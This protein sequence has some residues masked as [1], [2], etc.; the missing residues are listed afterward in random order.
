MRAERSRGLRLITLPERVEALLWA[1][2]RIDRR[3]ASREPLFHMYQPYARSIARRHRQARCQA[4]R[5]DAEQWAYEGLLQAIDSYDPMRGSPFSGFAR[6]RIVGAIRDGIARSTELDA[7][8]SVR[9]R[10]EY[11]RLR[12]LADNS[13]DDEDALRQVARIAVDLAIGIMLEASPMVVT[14]DAPDPDGT[15]YDSL[16]WRQAQAKLNRAVATLSGRESSV[17]LNHYEHGLSFVQ[18]ATLLGLSR[19]RV[20]Q[21]HRDALQRLRKR[22]SKEN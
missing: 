6:Q 18:I 14:P 15:A 12:S 11:E 20:S 9:R 7:Q 19:S 21:I 13:G 2:L 4:D 3:E 1:T 10:L 16:S 8:H 5:T 22:M 17:I